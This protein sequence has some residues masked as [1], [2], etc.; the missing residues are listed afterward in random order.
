MDW[1]YC[2]PWSHDICIKR[3]GL[4]SKV[5]QTFGCMRS[6]VKAEQSMYQRMCHEI[7][8][9]RKV[10]YN[11]SGILRAVAH[12]AVTDPVELHTLCDTGAHHSTAWLHV[13]ESGLCC[14]TAGFHG[15]N[16]PRQRIRL[17]DRL[18]KCLRGLLLLL[19]RGVAAGGRECQYRFR[20][21]PA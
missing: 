7:V 9:P 15:W 17:V 13:A 16:A 21:A 19:A 14:C 12:S 1:L 10:M 18:P 4:A 11:A 6:C 8:L 3:N 5:F 20:H 2:S